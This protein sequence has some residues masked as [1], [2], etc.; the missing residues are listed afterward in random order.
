MAVDLDK[1]DAEGGTD[2][3]IMTIIRLCKEKNVP[4]AFSGLRKELGMAQYG[5]RLKVQPRASTLAI[6][7]YIGY[8]KVC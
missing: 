7:N 6:T 3:K 2:E 5:K 4:I 8:E 1:A